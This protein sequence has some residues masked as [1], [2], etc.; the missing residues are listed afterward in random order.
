MS[1]YL[2]HNRDYTFILARD[3]KLLTTMPGLRKKWKIAEKSII[4]LAQKCE[5]LNADGINI[6][7][8]T[9]P[10]QKYENETSDAL[11]KLFQHPYATSELNLLATIQTVLENYFQRKANGKTKENGKIIIVILDSEPADRRGLIKLLVKTTQQVDNNEELGILFAQVGE[12]PIT[13]GFLQ[14]LDNNLAKAGAK[15][16]IIDTKILN[17]LEEEQITDFL[18]HAILD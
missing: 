15:L 8:A 13:K 7:I 14:A 5:Q 4:A 11:V 17:E 9:T 10:L 18:L 6:Y 12:D 1:E 2:L 16:D 3:A